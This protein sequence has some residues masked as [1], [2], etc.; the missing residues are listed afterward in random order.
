[1]KIVRAD[2]LVSANTAENYPDVDLPEIALAGRSNVGKSSAINLLTGRKGL[3]I[4]SNTPGRTRLVNF[5]DV[6][7]QLSKTRVESLRLVDLPGYGFAKA[8]R[9]E[10]DEWKKRV[11]SYMTGR[12]SLRGVVHLIDIRHEPS[13]LD[14]QL[15]EWLRA[16]GRDEIAVFTKS[17]KLTRN[18][19]RSRIAALEKALGLPAGSGIPFSATEGEGRD[20]VWNEI[21]DAL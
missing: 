10:R 16:L 20:E 14:L 3:A 5:F 17:D 19:K 13:E 6:D 4:T 2:F 11:D 1:M 7:V 15:S 21:L 8:S 9:D 18:E 12:V